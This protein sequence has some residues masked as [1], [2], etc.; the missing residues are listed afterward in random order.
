M[1]D[2]PPS[3]VDSPVRRH[4]FFDNRQRGQ[5]PGEAVQS[6]EMLRACDKKRLPIP[7]AGRMKTAVDCS[8]Q[9]QNP[10]VPRRGIFAPETTGVTVFLSVPSIGS[11]AHCV[12]CSF[13]QPLI[14]LRFFRVFSARLLPPPRWVSR[15]TQAQATRRIPLSRWA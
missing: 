4:G 9:T 10:S 3:G 5:P 12:S 14:L 7:S 15:R 1:P 13:S 6:R 11:T 8:H 2:F